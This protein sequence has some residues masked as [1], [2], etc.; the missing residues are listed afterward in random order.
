MCEAL[1]EPT[2]A[3]KDMCHHFAFR[4]L[5][6]CSWELQGE[7]GNEKGAKT[8]EQKNGE[9]PVLILGVKVS[10]AV[11][12]GP[13]RANIKIGDSPVLPLGAKMSHAVG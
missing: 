1:L 10:H 8:A 6:G 11:G 4:V 3:A 13:K 9:R 5:N 7:F 2:P 12:G